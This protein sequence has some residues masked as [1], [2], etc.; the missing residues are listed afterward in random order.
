MILL[1]WS[2]RFSKIKSLTTQ[3]SYNFP[4][5]QITK[6]YCVRLW[7]GWFWM[8]TSLVLQ[9]SVQ[10]TENDIIHIL[11]KS[12]GTKKRFFSAEGWLNQCTVYQ[13]DSLAVSPSSKDTLVTLQMQQMPE[14]QMYTYKGKLWKEISNRLSWENLSSTS[15]GAD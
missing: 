3:T 12:L 10:R 9:K 11:S 13:P 4:D 7:D 5:F 6:L 1:C 14:N 8:D 15:F 2:Y